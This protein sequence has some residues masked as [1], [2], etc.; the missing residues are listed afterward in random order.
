VL[1]ALTIISR[2]FKRWNGMVLDM[3]VVEELVG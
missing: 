1:V 2:L 3:A